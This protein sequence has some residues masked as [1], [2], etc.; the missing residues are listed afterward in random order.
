VKLSSLL[1]HSYDETGYNKNVGIKQSSFCVDPNLAHV[2]DTSWEPLGESP[3]EAQQDW[4]ESQH[5]QNGRWAL[6]T[7]F[8]EGS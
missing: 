2:E 7:N 5:E 8:G 1:V 3:L 4:E 6:I